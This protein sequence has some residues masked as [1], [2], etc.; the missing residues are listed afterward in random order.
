MDTSKLK[1]FAQAARRQLREQ[2]SF[3]LEQV[4]KEDSIE[5]RDR[6][7]AVAE[8]QAEIGKSSKEAVVERVAYIW[9]NRFC[10]LRYMDVNR[11]TRIDFERLEIFHR[12]LATARRMDP[13]H[14]DR[15]SHGG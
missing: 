1:K 4:L 11:Y 10:A 3:R 5:S 15:C 14:D 8:L 9:F 12:Q 7:N 13:S 2:V 6:E